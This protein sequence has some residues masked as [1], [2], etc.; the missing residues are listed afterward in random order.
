MPLNCSIRISKISFSAIKIKISDNQ[1][2]VNKLTF[3]DDVI[4]DKTESE[5]RSEILSL[6]QRIQSA[7]DI[8]RARS[9]NK[10]VELQLQSYSEYT[11][12]TAYDDP[13]FVEV[14]NKI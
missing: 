7:Q 1:S 12:E 10:E 4:S 14:C 6:R 5:I 8:K 3:Y 9:K 2:T 13:S 11:A